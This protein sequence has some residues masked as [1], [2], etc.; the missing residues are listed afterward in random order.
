M[1]KFSFQK[2]WSQVKIGE[3]TAVRSKLMKA[4][5][6]TTRMAFH[7]RLKGKVVPKINEYHAIEKVFA[8]YGIKKVWGD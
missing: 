4:L 3:T 5:N 1:D 7:D 8:E 2:G 6:I